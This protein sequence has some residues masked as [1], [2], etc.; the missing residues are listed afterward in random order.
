MINFNSRALSSANV[1]NPDQG[2]QLISKGSDITRGSDSFN[3]DAAN[4]RRNVV[5]VDVVAAADGGI[6]E[7][8]KSKTSPEIVLPMFHDPSGAAGDVVI[9]DASVSVTSKSAAPS[10]TRGLISE[11]PFDLQ[12]KPE[13]AEDVPV[14]L[15]S[16]SV[17]PTEQRW[18]SYLSLLEWGLIC[19]WPLGGSSGHNWVLLDTKKLQSR[20]KELF[21]IRDKFCH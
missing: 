20:I 18:P 11:T 8:S 6:S 12:L 3:E 2:H 19:Q 15:E 14:V 21:L 5:V 7:A 9:N 10:D 13:A 4:E 17:S 16:P 1:S